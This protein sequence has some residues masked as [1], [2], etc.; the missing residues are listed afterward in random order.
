MSFPNI[1][2]DINPIEGFD[3][4]QVAL[5]L[6]ASIAFEELA[7]AHVMNAEA[8]KLQFA[9]GTLDDN[10]PVVEDLDDL[11]QINRSVERVLRTVVKKEMILQF[12]LEDVV[13]FLLDD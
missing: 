8:E 1:P 5:F 7:L 13:D 12:K 2:E 10:D 6:L 11:L 3:K 4:E 9:L